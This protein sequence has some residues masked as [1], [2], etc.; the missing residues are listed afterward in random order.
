MSAVEVAIGPGRDP[1]RFR[2]E[3]VRSPAGEASLETEL[4]VNGLLAGREL[5]QQALL[6][7]AVATRQM[8]SPL[9]RSVQGT[10]RA[11]FGALLGAGEVAGCYR[12]SVALADERGENLRVVLRLDAPELACL[13]WEAMYDPGTGGYLCRQHQL[14]RH[15]PVAAAPPPLEVTGPLRIL[16]V[17]SAPR[18]LATL[19]LQREREHLQRA[20][21]GLTGRGLAEVRWLPAATWAGLHEMLLDGP[22]H[23]LH[24]IGH[25]DFD[26]ERDEG[27]LA[28]E[29]E[30]GR[31]DL[32]QANRFVD[33]LRQARP[34]PRLVVLNSC[35]GATASTMDLFSGTAAALARGGA[36]A[37]TA[38]QHAI[39]DSAAVAFA[40]GFY[41][42]LARSRS[43]DEAVSAGRI[44]I[45]GTG[46]QTLEWITP[47]LYLRGHHTHLFA[48]TLLTPPTSA[49]VARPVRSAPSGFRPFQL[50]NTLTG[51]TGEVTGTAFSPD[52]SWFATASEDKT[53]RLWRPD[54][55]RPVRILT[56]HTGWHGE[57]AFSPDG[58]LLATA[59]TDA[60]VWLWD[61]AT[62]HPVH[63]L[64][65]HTEW[66]ETVV[67]SLDG[68]VLATASWDE[69]A[70]LWDTATGRLTHIFTDRSVEAGGV[71]LSP[72]GTMIAT[73]IDG[74]VHLWST[75]TGQA[76]QTLTGH[77][78]SVWKVA[79]SP[80][81]TLLATASSDETARLWD[82]A[83]GRPTHTL[84]GH[85]HEVVWLAF[86]PDSTL[87]A[88]ISKDKTARLWDTATGRPIH[89][90][91]GHTGVLWTGVFSPDGTLLATASSDETARLWDTAT[92]R[93]T[94]T[95]TG[96]AAD[97]V[98]LAFSPDGTML[99]TRS[100]RGAA[101]LWT[102]PP[103]SSLSGRATQPLRQWHGA[104]DLRRFRAD[105]ND[106]P[107]FTPS[108]PGAL[109][110]M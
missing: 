78:E 39:S 44:A 15:I 10:G 4:D 103:T 24:F 54:L 14:V 50:A 36:A 25:G 27:V 90:L 13:P 38:M 101:L 82:T 74:T 67:F 9:E 43:V 63:I 106:S 107:C 99:A 88:T 56:G 66:V 21:V 71:D 3:V 52:G 91:A 35:S 68:T 34:M 40:R 77:T 100:M 42:S 84:T 85:T 28:L 51:H 95:L 105:L 53:V 32:V 26:P 57:V 33:L 8:L 16:G 62:G 19:D 69:T 58:R 29:R 96:H 31:A 30:D 94:H 64:S 49:I 17:I 98:Q 110:P 41:A 61:I 23:V 37:V 83:T 92:G 108:T 89:V 20:V 80:D 59:D 45:L 97:V 79:F 6:A 65:G 18:G 7:S 48:R 104:Y 2:V 109:G 72:D 11:L 46:S 81:G 75:T 47:V 86:S 73:S 12:A 22:W 93:P 87:L 1:G 5:F 76:T 70:R 55:G 102:E 60:K